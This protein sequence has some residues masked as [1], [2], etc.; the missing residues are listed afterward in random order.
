MEKYIVL[1]AWRSKQPEEKRQTRTAG[2]RRYPMQ[3]ITKYETLSLLC[4]KS[5]VI[6]ASETVGYFLQTEFLEVLD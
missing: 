1:F 2:I 5:A 3:I 4:A 6:G